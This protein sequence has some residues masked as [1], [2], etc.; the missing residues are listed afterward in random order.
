MQCPDCDGELEADDQHHDHLSPA[1]ARYRCP[2]CGARW[3]RD[4]SGLLVEMD[5]F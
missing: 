2:D 5:S 1:G 3:E 4:A